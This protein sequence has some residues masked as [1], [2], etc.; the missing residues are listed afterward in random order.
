MHDRGCSS[1]LNSKLLNI[2]LLRTASG[3]RCSECRATNELQTAL[4]LSG[5]PFFLR[6]SRACETRAH[7]KITPREKRRVSPFLACGDFHA[8]S[9]FARSIPQE[10]WGTTRSLIRESFPRVG[11]FS[12]ALAL[13]TLYYPWGKIV[14]TRSLLSYKNDGDSYRKVRIKPKGDHSGRGL[15]WKCCPKVAEHR[16]PYLDLLRYLFYFLLFISP[17]ISFLQWLKIATHV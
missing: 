11:W 1:V 12:R 3:Q 6:D 14:A 16:Q 5:P 7:V 4:K 10:K 9:R 2:P 8:R 17:L 15:N 13:R